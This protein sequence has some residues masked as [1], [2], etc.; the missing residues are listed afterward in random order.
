MAMPDLDGY[1]TP[2]EFADLPSGAHHAV[3]RA[4]AERRVDWKLASEG[5]ASGARVYHREQV[6]ALL[7]ETAEAR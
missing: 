2:E 5:S 4:A 3:W 7:R 6:L 1:M